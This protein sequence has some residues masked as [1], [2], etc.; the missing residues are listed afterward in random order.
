MEAHQLM[1]AGRLT[2]AIRALKAHL[3]REPG[4][5]RAQTF[6]YELICF[7][8][9]LDQAEEYLDTL[10]RA[11][12]P[13]S[14]NAIADYKRVLKAEKARQNCFANREYPRQPV[15]G[16]V[17]AFSG[18]LNGKGFASLSDADPRIG[19][20]L[21]LFVAGEYLWISL[22]EVRELQLP[23][24]RRLRD[25]L[26]LPVEVKVAPSLGTTVFKDCWLPMM[27]PLSWQHPDEEVKLGRV[28]EWKEDQ[29]GQAAPYGI[30][31]Y[32]VDGVEVPFAEI[33]N[34][35]IWLA[36]QVPAEV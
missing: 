10:V 29:F 18:A 24:P 36:G 12:Q 34:L 26:W 35:T 23:A 33:R 2:E 9:D 31:S 11:D 15:D 30:K 19:E 25:L 17:S 16:G 1:K 14:E 27:A 20:K 4:D 6:L 22:Y 13:G 32:L 28:S 8:G 7:T 3:A 5:Y 21:E